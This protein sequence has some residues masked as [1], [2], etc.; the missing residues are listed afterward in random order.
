MELIPAQDRIN[1]TAWRTRSARHW[2]GSA[3]DWTDPG[4]AAA[5]A[6]VADEVRDQPLL[7][8]GVGGGRTVPFLTRISSDYTAVDYTPEL[9][10]ICRRNHP[11]VRVHHMDAR[12]MAAFSDN[13]FAL[14]TFSFNGIDSVDYDGR[15]AI[16]REFARVLK[17]GGLVLFS[18]HNLHGPSYRENL[19]YL[20]RMPD[21]SG[22]PVGIA[23]D[24][25]RRIYTL[26]IGTVNF[27]RYSKLNRQFDGCAVRVCAAH[28]FGVLIMYT[29]MEAQHRQLAEAGLETEI[30]FGKTGSRGLSVTDDVSRES[31]FHFVARKPLRAAERGTELSI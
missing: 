16:L 18:T 28:K 22:G 5:V 13:T 10:E 2:Y 9:V 31:W 11:G 4:E 25:A 23:I 17:P 12:N 29:E 26:P 24:T 30:V 6:W 3:N 19:W 15:R 21:L 8:V 7:D 27:L 14:V 1:R 20:L